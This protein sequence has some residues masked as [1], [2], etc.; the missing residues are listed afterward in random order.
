R[1]QW[2]SE[3]HS[4]QT[5]NK[6]KR[7]FLL[8]IFKT[9]GTPLANGTAR[10]KLIE[11]GRALANITHPNVARI[12]A[13]E[14]HEDEMILAEEF[15]SP[16]TFMEQLNRRDTLG[17]SP[18][19]IALTSTKMAAALTRGIEVIHKQGF[20]CGGL[21]PGRIRF[22]DG[23]W[24]QPVI[25]WFGDSQ[26][27]SLGAGATSDAWL[28]SLPFLPPECFGYAKVNS[29]FTADLY[30]IGALLFHVASGR[31]P[32]QGD[33]VKT[34]MSGICSHVSSLISDELPG[35]P[36]QL[37]LIVARLLR[38]SPQ[39]R[40]QT[41]QG[42][43]GDLDSCLAHLERNVPVPRFALGRRDTLRE[44]NTG[45]EFVGRIDELNKILQALESATTKT[46]QLVTIGA[47]SG[48][49]KSRLASETLRHTAELGM[50]QFSTK[51]SKFERNVPLS[52]FLRVLNSHQTWIK[53]LGSDQLGRW[54][55]KILSEM[56]Q[57][58]GLL[59]KRIEFY[60]NLLPD[61]PALPSNLRLDE[62][63]EFF[64][65]TFAKFI[66]TLHP[67][68]TAY[69]LYFDDIQWADELS[70]KVFHKLTSILNS[71]YNSKGA[72]LLG[73]FRSEEV[74]EED[75]LYRSVLKTIPAQNYISL[76]PLNRLESN[77]FVNNLLNEDEVDIRKIQS[78][79]F[80][81]TEGNPLHLQEYIGAI[82]RNGAF[83]LNPGSD[84]W[85]IDEGKLAVTEIGSGI[86][87]LLNRRLK[88]LSPQAL[89]V[90]TTIATVSS[91][92]SRSSL[93]LLLEK[94]LS[95]L[96]GNANHW[97]PLGI[98]KLEKALDIFIDELVRE[99][100]V[101]LR[102]DAVGIVHDRIRESAYPMLSAEERQ[103]L[104][105][106][107]GEFIGLT[108]LGN[109][110]PSKSK[111]FFEAGF[112]ILRGRPQQH[113][114]TSRRILHAAGRHAMNV[115]SYSHA[116]EF[117]SMASALLPNTPQHYAENSHEYAE[118]IDI[119]ELHAD[120]QALSEKIH[121]SIEN[122]R[123]ILKWSR[124]KY[125]TA[126]LESK[127]SDTC[128]QLFLYSA[129][130]EAGI[131]GLNDLGERF[132]RSQTLALM[133]LLVSIPMLLM[134]IFWYRFFATPKKVVS[135]R[136]DEIRWRL[137][138]YI[139]LPTFFIRPAFALA[140]IVPLTRRALAYKPNSN[141]ATLFAFWGVIF[142][143]FGFSRASLACHRRAQ[144][145][146]DRHPSPVREMFITFTSGYL[147]DF[148]RGDLELAREKLQ[149]A[150]RAAISIG[151]SFW[152]ML[153]WQ[154]LNHVSDYGLGSKETP[155]VVHNLMAF[156][157]KI[158]W[159]TPISISAIRYLLFHDRIAESR[160][161]VEQAKE[162]GFESSRLNYES[163][164][165]IHCVTEA[166]Q[167]HLLRDE[168]Q[169]AL[170]ILELGFGMVIRHLQRTGFCSMNPVQ[171]VLARVRCGMRFRSFFP[172]AVA[173]FN[174]FTGVRVF[175]PQTLF[176]TAELLASFGFR[177]AAIR[178][179]YTATT[180]AQKNGW[181]NVAAELNLSTAE[182][183]AAKD[184]TQAISLLNLANE[185]FMNSGNVFLHEKCNKM[186]AI[187][188]NYFYQ[189][190][191]KMADDLGSDAL[192]KSNTMGSTVRKKID[193]SAMME[194]LAK[195]SVLSDM[196]SLQDIILD[197]FC[198]CTGANVG[199]VMMKTKD[200][201]EV[202]RCRNISLEKSSER[203]S[204]SK[205]FDNDFIEKAQ[206][207][208]INQP[209]VRI[210]QTQRNS[211][212]TTLG[213]S[214]AIPLTQQG[215]T[216]CLVFLGN[217]QLPDL[218]TD[219]TIS[220]LAPMAN[221]AAIAINNIRLMQGREEQLRMESDLATAK[222][223]Q[224]SILPFSSLPENTRVASHYEPAGKTGGDWYGYYY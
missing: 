147:L 115:F 56:G 168:P 101:I 103:V 69:V 17:N 74:S 208:S 65:E 45:V 117:L 151:D 207:I 119:R 22:R 222:A 63:E 46:G 58:G 200:T 18:N 165:A 89:D 14:D 93:Q 84:R 166:G 86:D 184:P 185:Y 30:S 189:K 203:S 8:R 133:S 81:L 177:R 7:E 205:L 78:I 169:E 112:H 182:F 180:L 150:L 214:L 55:E 144:N 130:M 23:D 76:G 85:Q 120:A 125:R 100:L 27:L 158:D 160:E 91:I 26:A 217:E 108:N 75:F 146:F 215:I 20:G 96:G 28:R 109:N 152:R 199:F 178:G 35:F 6:E 97:F 72:F 223:V 161:I 73:T 19:E 31:P 107:Y 38:K 135:S 32:V 179:M 41:A 34:I 172:L 52:G 159:N 77:E 210:Q 39:V 13:I 25:S 57:W 145:F 192:L 137:R 134:A 198:T 61:F 1:D 174:V 193:Q 194:M 167:F 50:P 186:L 66:L 209:L 187:A 71:N 11:Q 138:V 153:C 163:I 140:H 162:Y 121:A 191:P 12:V 102:S 155:S 216:F 33:S 213:S 190:Y 132:P 5:I 92:V 21:T 197:T 4:V 67:E 10:Q 131:K 15:C 36:H 224:S 62:E 124:E 95:R 111:E 60:D 204:A 154:G 127:L 211:Q 80:Q 164:E 148:P 136:E 110:D 195:L 2:V 114:E 142:A 104:H 116:E 176:A 188:R 170:P 118:W 220:T 123:E 48:V 16:V 40:Y 206:N 87:N 53:K 221:Q 99:H 37:S 181:K 122:Y 106:D 24:S 51:Y 201:W 43:L 83:Y 183:L 94:K 49:G 3:F 113:P 129:S 88:S 156:R 42:L 212:S 126:L 218:F 173:W 70:L 175:L 219:E 202:Q 128:L 79:A 171:L 196:D 64:T 149:Q 141:T 143:V 139:V 9:A 59:R 105:Q 54:R 29:P 47:L 82:L 157:K 68:Q 44:L 90:M 98:E